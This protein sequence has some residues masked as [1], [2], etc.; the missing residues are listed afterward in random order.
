[1]PDAAIADELREA[2]ID[3]EITWI[4][5]AVGAATLRA[6]GQTVID[7]DL[8]EH[9][10]FFETLKR[11]EPIV[12]DRR[13]DII[14]S[15]EEFCALP[16]AKQL[17]IRNVLLTDW[18]WSAD[19]LSTNAASFAD[20]ILFLDEPGYFPIPDSLIEKVSF[21]G[22]VFRRMDIR[23]L[24]MS[25]CRQRR[26]L[27]MDEPVLLVVPGGADIHSETRAPLFDALCAAV[28]G[29]GLDH[30]QVLWVVGDPDYSA[31]AETTEVKNGR[32]RLL[33]PHWEFTETLLAADVVLTKS[34]RTPLLECEVLGI[35]TI[36]IS[37]GYNFIDDFRIEQIATNKVLRGQTLIPSELTAAIE[38]A[39]VRCGLD[40]AV[41][42]D[43]LTQG[44]AR[45][46]KRLLHHLQL[47]VQR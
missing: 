27:R 39:L 5:Y 18:L 10:D 41:A 13:P 28:I 37:W 29:T 45:T 30:L 6:L 42:E 43:R 35:P 19:R 20:E 15:H 2:P 33:R 16:V 3:V 34:N 11:L 1:M 46:V 23:G 8:P 4:S 32:V 21:V 22:T 44:R 31:L 14:V 38:D 12:C 17:G 25:T 36:S 7:L 9:N 40:A 47:S 26:G 24:N